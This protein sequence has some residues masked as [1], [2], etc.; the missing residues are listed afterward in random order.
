MADRIMVPNG[1]DV[2]VLEEVII[3]SQL[4]VAVYVEQETAFQSGIFVPYDFTGVTLAC[5]VRDN[6]RSDQPEVSFDCVPR[7]AEPGWVDL[8]LDGT[9]TAMLLDHEYRASLKVWP[10][11]SPEL[12]DT[13]LVIVMPM[14]YEATR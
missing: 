2:L 9:G 13:L 3:G 5:D 11:G 7:V 8:L 6:L 14:K 10:T 12:G 4:P 1:P